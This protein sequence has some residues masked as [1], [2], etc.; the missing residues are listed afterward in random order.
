M[1]RMRAAAGYKAEGW[2][3]YV[4]LTPGTPKHIRKQ[5]IA[6]AVSFCGVERI[7]YGT[8]DHLPGE[9]SYQKQILDG[10]LAIF[11]ELGLT[12]AQKERILSGTAD[13]LFPARR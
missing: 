9:L 13:E 6:N 4:D 1:G 12:P 5:A 2:Q 3:S 7:L 11:N 8:D 10:D